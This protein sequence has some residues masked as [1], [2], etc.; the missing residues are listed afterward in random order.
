MRV[1]G[2]AGGWGLRARRRHVFIVVVPIVLRQVC[3]FP[4]GERKKEDVEG[5]EGEGEAEEGE[6]EKAKEKEG[7]DRERGG[8]EREAVEEKE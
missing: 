5:E 8:R 7:I 3:V 4:P 6:E 2:E 1:P